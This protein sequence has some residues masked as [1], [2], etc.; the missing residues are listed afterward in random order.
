MTFPYCHKCAAFAIVARRLFAARYLSAGL[1]VSGTPCCRRRPP[2]T[3]LYSH[4]SEPRSVPARFPTGGTQLP[5]RSLYRTS[6]G[7][8]VTEQLWRD[9]RVAARR[10]LQARARQLPPQLLQLLTRASRRRRAQPP[11]RP[12][13]GVLVTSGAQ[14]SPVRSVGVG[15]STGQRHSE[16]VSRATGTDEPPPRRRVVP[17]VTRSTS[18]SP[19]PPAPLPQCLLRPTWT[20]TPPSYI[21]YPSSRMKFTR[22]PSADSLVAP[23]GP[24]GK[25]AKVDAGL[26]QRLENISLE[27]SKGPVIVFSEADDEPR[28]TS[29]AAGDS[30]KH[31]LAVPAP[32]VHSEPRRP[33]IS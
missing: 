8:T 21:T 30:P 23:S 13:P 19:L 16:R 17:T 9:Q 5:V 31:S 20:S 3:A 10:L 4:R 26:L 11:L 25:A 2:A 33:P 6:P 7:V 27:D 28:P 14:T 15:Q 32:D 18:T 24:P 29:A 1:A 22:Q 12:C